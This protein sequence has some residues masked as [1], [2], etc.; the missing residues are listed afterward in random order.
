M[1]RGQPRSCL[2]H[3]GRQLGLQVVLYGSSSP[4]RLDQL[5]SMRMKRQE[6]NA[7][8][9]WPRGCIMMADERAHFADRPGAMVVFVVLSAMQLALF[10][11]ESSLGQS[12]SDF[13][14]GRTRITEVPARHRISGSPVR[15]RVLSILGSR[16]VKIGRYLGWCPGSDKD[17]LRPRPKIQRVRQ[18][19]RARKLILTAFL[20]HRARRGCLGVETLVDYVVTLRHKLDGRSLYDGSVSPPAKRWPRKGR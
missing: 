18:V 16:R 8:G 3:W 11:S 20:I 5:R 9:A 7:S 4:D 12:A 15:W 13:R 10:A 2:Q 19:E 6:P 17:N 1:G 14:T